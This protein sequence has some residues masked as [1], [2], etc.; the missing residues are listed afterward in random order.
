MVMLQ[1]N[2][3]SPLVQNFTSVVG[4]NGS[5][6]S[7]VIDALLFVM[8]FKASKVGYR[9]PDRPQRCIA[10]VYTRL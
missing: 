4:P 5:G 6:K 3:L 2:R 9:R 8:A 10:C 1:A 7:N